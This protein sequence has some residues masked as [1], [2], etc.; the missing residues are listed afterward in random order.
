MDKAPSY[1]RGFSRNDTAFQGYSCPK[2]K[3]VFSFFD[4]IIADRKAE[5]EFRKWNDL[6]F[7]ELYQ[8][9]AFL[10]AGYASDTLD[11]PPMRYV[12]FVDSVN[13]GD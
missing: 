9:E 5:K 1:A 8:R 6:A 12:F 10:D 3:A 13:Q 2:E 11:I 4:A 7:F